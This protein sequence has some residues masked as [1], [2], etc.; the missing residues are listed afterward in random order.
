MLSWQL[1]KWST[2][3]TSP[4]RPSGSSR[5]S[6]TMPATA[7]R[8][9][10]GRRARRGRRRCRG[11]R[12]PG[13]RCRGR[14][15]WRRATARWYS[16]VGQHHGALRAAGHRDRRSE[17]TVVGTDEHTFAVGD[18]DRDRLAA[19]ADAG[20][21]DGEHDPGG[22]YE[23]APGQ[24]QAAGAHVERSRSRGVRSIIAT[25]GAMSRMTALT[26][27]TNS[28]IEAVVGEERDGVVATAHG[29]NLATTVARRRPPK[30]DKGRCQPPDGTSPVGAALRV[31]LRVL[32]TRRSF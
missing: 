8:R 4:T 11:G 25:C 6:G 26:T 23:I 22:R 10:S 21:D 30:I 15:T 5:D 17:Q 27:P 14:R 3:S 18:L 24:R 20:V 31:R 2:H 9:R 16:L 29:D 13:R 28:S 19:A 1:P 7:P 32:I 12:R